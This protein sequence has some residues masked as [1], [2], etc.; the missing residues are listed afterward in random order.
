MNENTPQRRLED[1][2]LNALDLLRDDVKSLNTRI[3]LEQKGV[4]AKLDNFDRSIQELALTM[5]QAEVARKREYDLIQRLMDEDRSFGRTIVQDDLKN[6]TEKDIRKEED[7]KEKR[8]YFVNAIKSVWDKGGHYI[9]MAICLII[10]LK[11]QS[12]TNLNFLQILG[13]IK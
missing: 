7:T 9:V 11:L 8:Q 3:E 4:A 2:F 10:V 13:V 1:K 5:L 12:C 6:K